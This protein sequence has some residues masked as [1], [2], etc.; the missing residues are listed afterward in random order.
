MQPGQQGCVRPSTPD[1]RRRC[2]DQRVGQRGRRRHRRAH[3]REGDHLQFRGRPALL[4]GH[5]GRRGRHHR[6]IAVHALWGRRWTGSE[7]IST[8]SSAA[9]TRTVGL[10]SR[11]IPDPRARADVVAIYAF[12]HELARALSVTREPLMA[13]IR[14]TWWADAIAEIFEVGAARRHPVTLALAGAV[15]RH[16]LCFAGHSTPW[17]RPISLSRLIGLRRRRRR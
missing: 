13:E 10:A 6:C 1:A 8:P 14:L 7:T 17:S 9:S 11:F 12:E 15:G 3:E 5:P 4:R 16:G 2:V